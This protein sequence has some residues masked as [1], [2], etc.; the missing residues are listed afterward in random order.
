[1]RGGCV[2]SHPRR[3]FTELPYP[4]EKSISIT[5]A[6]IVRNNCS[7]I[8]TLGFFVSLYPLQAEEKGVPARELS[9][10]SP[11]FAPVGTLTLGP[12]DRKAIEEA[13]SQKDFTSAEEKLIKL[14]EQSPNSPHL[15]TLLGRIFF[16]D[17]KP[18]NSAVALKKSEKLQPLKEEE[19]FL[20]AMAYV[21]LNR[22]DW[23]RSELEKLAQAN[24]NNPRYAY[25]L[26]RLDYD[27]T[28]YAEAV[29]KL[30]KALEL[31]PAFV[32]GYDNLG[33][34]YEGLGN[35]E[36]AKKSYEKANEL[37]RQQLSHSAWPP[38]NYG[39]LLLKSGRYEE[40][41][42]LLREALGY[43]EKL[44]ETRFQLGNVLEKE[45]KFKE[46]IEELSA[47]ATLDPSYPEPHYALARIYR[48][49]GDN[50]RAEAAVQDFQR[51]KQEKQKPKN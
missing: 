27:E 29:E 39:T 25:W 15:L 32:K 22:K 49:M 26:G 17:G 24:L 44:A 1:V 34:C 6:T 33:L 42:A 8:L 19:D 43:D 40:A 7:L 16:M 23:A 2:N 10:D 4:P 30:K 13:I 36:E 14:I 38:L 18:L 48:N 12:A 37:N 3:R 5:R 51:L 35:L 20:L 47:A 21:V 31:D 45:K 46:A 9:K 28:R 41:E 50:K 11:S